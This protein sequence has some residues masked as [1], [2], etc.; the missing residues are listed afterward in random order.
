LFDSD[1]ILQNIRP[2]FTIL[3]NIRAEA[4]MESDNF[5]III[6]AA[7]HDHDFVSRFFAPNAGI[8][9]D[10]VTGRAHCSLI[11]FWSE[12]LDRT[13][14]TARQLSKRGGVLYCEDCGGRVK[15]GGKAVRYL[16]GNISI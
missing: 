2:D 3:K 1:E 6:T 5:G 8:D 15:I 9:E 12:K 11:P 14:L 10:P 4:E 13:K 7:G 16:R